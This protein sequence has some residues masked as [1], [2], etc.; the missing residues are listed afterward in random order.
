MSQVRTFLHSQS[1]LA[2][3]TPGK[4]PFNGHT[5]LLTNIDGQVETEKKANIWFLMKKP[6]TLR[7]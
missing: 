2:A 6:F 4:T 3:P 5:G 7:S 1:P